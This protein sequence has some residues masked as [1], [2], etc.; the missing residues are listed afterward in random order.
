[1]ALLGL[2]FINPGGAVAR[3][4]FAGRTESG[5]MPKTV[6]GTAAFGAAGRLPCRAQPPATSADKTSNVRRIV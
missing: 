6:A 4:I 3:D 2:P 1:M 5:E